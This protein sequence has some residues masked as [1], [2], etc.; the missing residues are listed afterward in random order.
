M[1]KSDLLFVASQSGSAI[2][3][4]Y[5]GNENRPR[6][7]L[8]NSETLDRRRLGSALWSATVCRQGLQTKPASLSATPGRVR[9]GGSLC[10]F[11]SRKLRR[12]R[13]PCARAQRGLTIAVPRRYCDSARL[14]SD[15]FFVGYVSRHSA[16]SHRHQRSAVHQSLRWPSLWL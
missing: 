11:P 4:Y 7:F 5:D 1:T 9:R 14:R 6:L 2:N 8:S 3:P 12:A 13:A 15:A 10:T 16:G